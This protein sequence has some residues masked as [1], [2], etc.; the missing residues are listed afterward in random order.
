MLLTV[1]LEAARWVADG[2]VVGGLD[3]PEIVGLSQLCLGATILVVMIRRPAGLLGDHELDE[4]LR[5]GRARSAPVATGAPHEP[6]AEVSDRAAARLRVREVSKSFAGIAALADVSLEVAPGAIVGVIGPNGAGKT[7]LLNVLSGNLVPTSG[8]IELDGRRID[9]HSPGELA[10]RGIARTFQNLRLFEQLSVHDN[11]EVSTAVAA[12]HGSAFGRSTTAQLLADFG[13]TQRASDRAG[14]LA[15][16]DRR[17]LEM[18]RAVALSPRVLLLDEPTAGMNELE[19]EDLL[20]RINEVRDRLRCG[21]VVVDHNVPFIMELCEHIHV[22]NGGRQIAA[23]VPAEI[24]EHPDVIE[25]Y[26]GLRAT[27]GSA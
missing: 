10:R 27:S 5:F 3:L 16:G 25:A 19:A 22:L 18:A 21:V 14:T 23:G 12:R 2:P 17:R 20:T 7:T 15:Q 24:Q 8:S 9:G 1:I 26:L 6:A 4:L 13:L 11:V